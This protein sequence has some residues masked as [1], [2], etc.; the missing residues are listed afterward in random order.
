MDLTEEY[1]NLEP[2]ISNIEIYK[3]KE[4]YSDI[5]HIPPEIIYRSF[6]VKHIQKVKRSLLNIVK[7]TI[8]CVPYFMIKVEYK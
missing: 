4:F 1:V 5:R 8:S 6:P 2:P 7:L 3:L